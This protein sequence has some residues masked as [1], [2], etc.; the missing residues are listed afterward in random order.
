MIDNL[1][2]ILEPNG[3]IVIMDWYIEKLS[4]RGKFINWIGKGEVN[5]PIWQYLETRISDRH[6]NH[7]FK[8]GDVFV[9]SGRKLP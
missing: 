7:S 8:S 5:K 9:A 1:I 6:I 2:T 3:K 4:L